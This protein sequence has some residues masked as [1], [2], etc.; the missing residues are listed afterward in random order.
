MCVCV[1]VCVCRLYSHRRE[2]KKLFI[3][4]ISLGTL[5][6]GSFFQNKTMHLYIPVILYT[7]AFFQNKHVV[8]EIFNLI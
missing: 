7:S 1:C 6:M 3:F 8:F 2:L 5:R 4:N